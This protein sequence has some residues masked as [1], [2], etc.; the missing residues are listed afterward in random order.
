MF[1]RQRK[2]K[3][4][5]AVGCGFVLSTGLLICVL[6]VVN[7][8]IVRAFLSANLSH[9]DQRI[10]QAAQFIVPVLMIFFE[11]WFYDLVSRRHL[12]DGE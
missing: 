12:G 3:R 1:G 10:I 2:S 6:L 4:G 11:L 8:L 9:A 7:A 5:S